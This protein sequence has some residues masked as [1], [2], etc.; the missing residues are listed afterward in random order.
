MRKYTFCK[1]DYAFPGELP[2]CLW[3][4]RI[5]E[6]DLDLMQEV[7]D[8]VLMEYSS[9]FWNDEHNRIGINTRSIY[10]EV[11]SPTALGFKRLEA[12]YKAL[13]DKKYIYVNKNGGWFFDSKYPKKVETITKDELIWPDDEDKDEIITISSWYK[14]AHFYLNSTKRKFDFKLDSLEDAKQEALKFVSEK[15]IKIKTGINRVAGEGD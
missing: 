8:K 11:I 14:G 4:L 12:M 10:H 6:Y 13:E 15:Q 1:F 5:G 2:N 7:N 3:L 9:K